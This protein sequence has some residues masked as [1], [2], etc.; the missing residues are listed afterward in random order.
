MSFET[1]SAVPGE[2]AL[3]IDARGIWKAFERTQALSGASFALRAGEI[4]ALVGANGAGKS[5]FSRI[6]SGHL[7][8]DRGEIFMFGRPTRFGSAREAIQGGVTM[9]MQE[10]SLAPDLS[11]LENIYL[12]ELG[13]AGR[14]SWRNLTSR[15]ES[16]LDQFGQRAHLPLRRPVRE[17]SAGQL[18]MVEILKALALDAKVI[19]FDEPTAS[20]SPNEV[21]RLFDIM[22]LLAQGGKALVFVSHRLEEIFEITDRITVFREG[23]TVASAAP[24]AEMR[25]AELVRLMVG[26]EIADIYA[27]GVDGR[28]EKSTGKPVIEVEHLACAP[29]VKDVSF[30]VNSG[31]I[32]GLAGLIGAGRSECVEALFG[33]RRIERGTVRLSGSPFTARAP[34]EAVRAGIGFIPEDRRRQGLVQDF[35]VRENLLLAHLGQRRGLGL[36]YDEQSASVARLLEELG[37]PQRILD[38]GILTL[39]GGM[40]QKV[41]LAR[42]ILMSPKLLILD[43]PTRGVDIA[44]RSTIYA[45]I[46]RLAR[47][48]M[49]VL[50]VSSD[51]EEVIGLSDRIVVMSDGSDVTSIPSA[52][53]DVEKLAMFA[54]PRS[55]AEA[56]RSILEMLVQR[57]GGIAYWISMDGDRLYCFDSVAVQNAPEIGFARGS[58]PEIVDV[59]IPKAL[60]QRPDHFLLEPAGATLLVPLRGHRGH[61]LGYVGLTLANDNALPDAAAVRA[62][63]LDG[64]TT[65]ATSV[66]ARRH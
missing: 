61:D 48:G 58:F 29:R 14:L 26:R 22:R 21:D 3:A 27:R 31:E 41:V 6:V 33:L 42:W 47:Q 18:Q 40:Q 4:H 1:N 20:F 52:L 25:P 23:R 35:T 39:S 66:A 62:S 53:V 45:M 36:G 38:E 59:S 51:F 37:L 28:G 24:A 55:S 63:I 50:L 60:R 7:S 49:A 9:V 43:E 10:T 12:P 46:R 13:A 5:T 19:I 30:T 56:T 34:I 11:V 54:A 17:L 44:T 57:F 2:P 15:A 8:A 65:P 64:P 32:L 16:L